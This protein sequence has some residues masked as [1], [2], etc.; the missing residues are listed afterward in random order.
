MSRHGDPLRDLFR[1]QD[2]MNRVFSE[3]TRH[4]P[5]EPGELEKSDW[6]PAADVY[7]YEKEYVIAVDL[8][9]IDRSKLEIEI[10]KDQ[11]LVRGERA[12]EPDEARRRERPAG[13]FRR[14][15]VVPPNVDQNTVT[16]DYKDCVLRVRLEKR[17]QDKT[18][19]VQIPVH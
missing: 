19:K 17:A 3:L 13:S 5:S 9:G 15:F 8:P 16:A 10:E 14:R 2:R 11:L 4:Q 6:N 1:L 18:A 12:L 7:E